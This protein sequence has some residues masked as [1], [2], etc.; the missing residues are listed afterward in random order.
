M[1]KYFCVICQN[2]FCTFVAGSTLINITPSFR[3]K[4]SEMKT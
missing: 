3:L 2:N 1:K 4:R